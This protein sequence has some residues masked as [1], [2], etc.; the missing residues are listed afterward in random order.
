MDRH[1]RGTHSYGYVLGAAVGTFVLLSAGGDSLTVRVLAAIL[2]AVT[3]VLAYYTSGV[4]IRSRRMAL[5]VAALA[6]AASVLS[7]FGDDATARGITAVVSA[8][9]LLAASFAIIRGLGTKLAIDSRTVLG[10]LTIYLFV[11]LI[12]TYVFAAFDAFGSGPF[13]AGGK[14]ATIAHLVYFSFIT[15]TTV[16][17]GDFTAGTDVGRTIAVVEAL[18]GQLYLVTIVG[19]V[20][21]NIGRARPRAESAGRPESV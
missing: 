2:A 20:V 13:F 9:A 12:F 4:G 3:I 5:V 10:A 6:I 11:G 8:L 16:G 15:Q 21:G 17:Y 7:L 19:L 14:T 1:L 18:I